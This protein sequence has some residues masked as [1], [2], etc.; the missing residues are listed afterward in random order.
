[1]INNKLAIIK[2]PNPILTRPS[3]DIDIM[4]PNRKDYLQFIS[5]MEKMYRE[6]GEWG[7]MVGLAA[8]QVGR[9]W[10]VFVALN[11]VFVNPRLV[12]DSLRGYSNLREGCYSLDDNRYDY[13]TRRAYKVKLTW[14]DVNGDEHRQNFF[15]REAQ[16]VQHEYDH[17]Q[18]KLCHNE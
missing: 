4:G 8:P 9:N 14:L 15:G 7:Y 1:M 18:G 3:Q 11:Q 10:N 5:Q 13:P 6:G 12:I 17:L 16:V 2:Y